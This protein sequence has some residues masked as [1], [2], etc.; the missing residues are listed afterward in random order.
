MIF[1]AL[2]GVVLAPLAGGN[3]AGKTT[4][5]LAYTIY[6]YYIRPLCYYH[7]IYATR[8]ALAGANG[9]GKTTLQYILLVCTVYA[10]VL[11]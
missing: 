1:G 8:A 6:V 11:Y 7:T 9:A 10:T 3:G 2:L 4:L 5:L